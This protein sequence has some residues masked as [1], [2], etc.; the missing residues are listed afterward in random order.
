MNPSSLQTIL[1]ACIQ[2]RQNFFIPP[3]ESAFRLFNGFLEGCPSL[4]LDVYADT[5]VAYNYADPPESG[6]GHVAEAIELARVQLPWLGAAIVKSRYAASHEAR[7]GLLAWG[8]QPAR[9]VREHGVRYAINLQINQD[10]SFYADTRNLRQWTLNNSRDKNIL[11][12]FA[13][14]G[15]L[16]AAALAG[17]A[18]CVVQLDRS[19]AFLNLAKE[20]YTLNGFVIRKQDFLVA[21]FFPVISRLRRENALFDGVFLDPPFFS[22]TGKGV[23][24]QGLQAERLINKVRPLVRD[25]GWLAAVNNALFVSGRDYWATLE[26]LCADGFLEIE[27]LIPVPED[28]AGYTQTRV[29]SLPVDPTPF[30]HATKIAIL[31]IK[32]KIDSP[33]FAGTNPKFLGV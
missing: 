24:D 32:R 19:R 2:R 22:S 27:T 9:R 17:G 14:T 5:L 23:V 21:D 15:S 13:Y 3:N 33:G 31:R 25:G 8:K 1:T 7:R 26:A 18:A 30:N 16:G 20:T 10:A 4:A 6:A 28:C 11:N 29:A 12:T